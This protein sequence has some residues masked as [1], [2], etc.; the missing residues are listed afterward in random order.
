MVTLCSQLNKVT[1]L[2]N[3]ESVKTFNLELS[4]QL[5]AWRVTPGRV[6]IDKVLRVLMSF[7]NPC[8]ISVCVNNGFPPCPRCTKTV[9]EDS[10]VSP[11]MRDER[12]V[13][14][15]LW[16][17]RWRVKWSQDGLVSQKFWTFFRWAQTWKAYLCY[18]SEGFVE[19]WTMSPIITDSVRHFSSFF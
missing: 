9:S 6:Q 2:P 15:L 11:A 17:L 18:L 5:L 13:R 1:S 4:A 14:L 16:I 10:F 12:T 7:A 19:G 3:P 8:E